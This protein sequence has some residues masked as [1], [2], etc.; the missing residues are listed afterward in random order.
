MLLL[1]G[2]CLIE[3]KSTQ[4]GD[5]TPHLRKASFVHRSRT[6]Q[7]QK[8]KHQKMQSTFVVKVIQVPSNVKVPCLIEWFHLGFPTFDET[9]RNQQPSHHTTYSTGNKIRQLVREQI[10]HQD[11][12]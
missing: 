6:E 5:L 3:D 11:V 2:S 9:F 8:T 1:L 12:S 4:N 10:M 7:P